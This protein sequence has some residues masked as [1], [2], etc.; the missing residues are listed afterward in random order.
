[1]KPV[2]SVSTSGKTGCGTLHLTCCINLEHKL[3]RVSIQL[4]LAGGC[5]TATTKTLS[6]VLNVAIEQGASTKELVEA[7]QG[8][9][10][11]KPPCCSSVAASLLAE[12][13]EGEFIK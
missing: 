6:D 11:H 5:A 7:L 8:H 13:A 1:M 4:G 9:Q 12:I 2:M 3:E 10:C